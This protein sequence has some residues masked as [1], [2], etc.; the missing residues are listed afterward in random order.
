M[1]RSRVAT[2]QEFAEMV[3]MVGVAEA[4]T[5]PEVCAML[6]TWATMIG[7]AAKMLDGPVAPSH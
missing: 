6:C 7:D 1:H 4:E 5:K 3:A 2:M